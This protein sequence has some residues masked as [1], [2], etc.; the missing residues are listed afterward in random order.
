M[1][2]IQTVIGTRVIPY[3][4]VIIRVLKINAVMGVIE[5]L[6]VLY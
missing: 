1:D 3:S 6:I 4:I 5:A 2:S